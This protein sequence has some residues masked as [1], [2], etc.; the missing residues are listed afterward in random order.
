MA[1]LVLLV[2][3]NERW[4]ERGTGP[5]HTFYVRAKDGKYNLYEK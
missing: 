3:L 5:T 2:C 4:E 1:D